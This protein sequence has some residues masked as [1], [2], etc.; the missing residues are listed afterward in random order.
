MKAQA[1]RK[2]N[3][4]KRLEKK[5][6]LNLEPKEKKNKYGNQKTE[7]NGITF[8]SQREARRYEELM[9]MVQAGKIY[10]L[11]LQHHFT[12]QEAWISPQGEKIGKIEYLADFTYKNAE[13]GEFVVEDAKGKRTD[14]YIMKKKMMA[15]KGF[16]IKEV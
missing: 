5:Q 14:V 16:M 8:D 3:A 10:D 1:L 6:E 12:L 9:L 7:V 13:S 4:Q 11:R 15:D 2:L